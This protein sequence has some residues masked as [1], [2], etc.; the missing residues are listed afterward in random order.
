MSA[1]NKI[2]GWVFLP[3]V[4]KMHYI[5]NGKSVC[6]KVCGIITIPTINQSSNEVRRKCLDCKKIV[7]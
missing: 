5:R 3:G 1:I 7:E 4:R 2:E 6:G